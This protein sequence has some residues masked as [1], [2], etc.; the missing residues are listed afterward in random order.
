MKSFIVVYILPVFL[1]LS[2]AAPELAPD[3]PFTQAGKEETNRLLENIDRINGNAPSSIDAAFRVDGMFGKKKFKASGYFLYNDSA[4]AARITFVDSVFK[5][6][7]TTFVQDGNTIKV[8][9]P[10]ENTLVIDNTETIQLSD[11]MPVSVDYSFLR[12]MFT[13]RIPMIQDYKINRVL[14]PR[15]K[16]GST[17]SE[18]FIIIENDR[19]YETITFKD[20]LP[21]RILLVEKGKKKKYEFYYA[22]P[23]QKNKKFGFKGIEFVEPDTGN[24]L[25]IHFTKYKTNRSISRSRITRLDVKNNAKV[26]RK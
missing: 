23:A 26:F 24:K 16:D 10:V 2:C 4:A 19:Y 1:M 20:N 7:L 12:Q 9:F 17:T 15:K 5:S 3:R 18:I 25:D 8:H 6:P 11:Y 22:E 21:T 13:S 14:I